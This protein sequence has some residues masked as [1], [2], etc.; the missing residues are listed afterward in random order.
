PVAG[1]R[2][3]GFG[4]RREH[5]WAGDAR[6]RE[7]LG[8]L[9]PDVPL[10]ASVGGMSGGD[11]RRVAL[12][13]VLVPA[14]DVLLLDEPTNHLDL[15]AIAWLA[16]H[17]KD[18]TLLVVTHDR[19]FLDEVTDRTWEVADGCARRYDGG[20]SAYVLAKAER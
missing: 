3:L 2:E 19:W 10:D 12:A 17:L 5:E 6:V 4:Q 14:S 7:I 18:R 20:Y 11:R 1:V 15:E 13:A 8:G 9:L 16:G